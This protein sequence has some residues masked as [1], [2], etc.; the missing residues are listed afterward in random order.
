MVSSGS[1]DS[2]FFIMRP[3]FAQ[4]RGEGPTGRFSECMTHPVSIEAAAM[5]TDSSVPSGFFSAM[6]RLRPQS[7]RG[8]VYEQ[9]EIVGSMNVACL[10]ELNITNPLCLRAWCRDT[11]GLNDR[12]FVRRAKNG[13]SNCHL[14]SGCIRER[15]S[16]EEH[17]WLQPRLSYM[18]HS[19]SRSANGFSLGIASTGCSRSR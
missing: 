12:R 7:R 3:A 13:T 1:A 11:I 19:L 15:G 8:K 5:T 4:S 17:A 14:S 18:K 2:I 9:R 16:V 10:F 6:R